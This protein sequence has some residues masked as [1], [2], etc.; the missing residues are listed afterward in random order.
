MF[1][2]RFG[3]ALMGGWTL[4]LIW[5][6]FKPLE[7]RMAA[8]MTVLVVIGLIIAEILAIQSGVLSF[9]RALTSLIIQALILAV[10]SFVYVV[11]RPKN[12]RA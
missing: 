7:R 10:Y 5:A 12:L 4:F 11:S 2:M 6:S 3:A 9:G 8:P 1:A